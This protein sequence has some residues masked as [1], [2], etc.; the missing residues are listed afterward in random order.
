[1]VLQNFIVLGIIPGTN[2]Q[3]NFQLW[4][5]IVLA[6][7]CTWQFRRLLHSKLLAAILLH[8]TFSKQRTIELIT[9]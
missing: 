6:A 4:L 3:I 9:L 1:M 5:A 8:Q 2:I 7:Y